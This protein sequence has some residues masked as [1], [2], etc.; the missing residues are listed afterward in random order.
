MP[1]DT[2]AAVIQADREYILQTYIRPDMVIERGEGVYLYD[3]EG[4]AYL[5][6]V[7]GIAVNALGYG[8]PDVT[9]VINQQ[10]A[11]LIHISNLFHNA[12][13]TDLARMLVTSSPAFDKVFFS[14]SGTEVVEGAI[15]FARRYARE[16]HG[17]G[18]TTIIAC[19]GSFHGRTMGAVAITS[20]EKYREPFMPVMP[21]VRFA[22]YNDIAS[23][24]AAMGDD[25]CA[26]FIEPIQGEGGLRVASDEFLAAARTLCDQHHALLVFDEIQC[27]M[28]RSGTL[29]AHH[30]SG[31][32]PDMMT[33]AKP[34]AGGLPIGA[35]L[36]NQRIADTIHPG[37]HGTTFGGNPL[38]TAVAGVVLQKIN[39]PEFLAHVREVSNYLDE[40]LQ[41]LATDMPNQIREIRG[42]G[43]MRGFQLHGSAADVRNAALNQGLLV[44]TSGEDVIRLL[45]PL[46]ITNQH[47][48]AAIEK[49]RAALQ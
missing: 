10:A 25:V 15:K 11:K 24:E 9:A 37:D 22:N 29:W 8:D 1:A 34:L 5:D 18:K 46:I 2:A 38:A 48:D 33:V 6:F 16:H 30:A 44:G 14:N 23:L 35:V 39:T 12:P 20:R 49:L 31:V 17:E 43:L 4:R 19:D 40:S 45:P 42:R 21:G 36:L 7:A 28:G 26:L 13:A 32:L 41:D 27:G 3:T 47:V